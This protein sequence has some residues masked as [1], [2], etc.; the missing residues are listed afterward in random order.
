MCRQRDLWLMLP[1]AMLTRRH[2]PC[3]WCYHAPFWHEQVQLVTDATMR[4]FDTDTCSLWLILP[5]AILTRT[6]AACNWC[7]HAPFWHGHVQ[8]IIDAT[9]RHFDTEMCS[10]F[11]YYHVLFWHGHV[12][13]L[14]ERQ[15][16][17]GG[18]NGRPEKLQDVSE[19]T[20][21]ETYSS[22]HEA[23]VVKEKPVGLK[24]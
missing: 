10:L 1:C 8:L 22:Y 17:S 16:P 24:T 13:R 18:L 2:T 11:W 4:H 15:T 12:H 21:G 23:L 14:C 3:N 9:M 19:R 20:P 5:C 7:Y 6:R